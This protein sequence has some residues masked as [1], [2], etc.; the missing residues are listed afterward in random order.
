MG[1]HVQLTLENSNK[2]PNSKICRADFRE[3]AWLTKFLGKKLIIFK[4]W[5]IS[6][7]YSAKKLFQTPKKVKFLIFAN[8]L[9]I[10]QIDSK[11]SLK[12]GFSFVNP[13]ATVLTP[14]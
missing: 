9:Q 10:Y 13:L 5:P 2:E 7:V 3:I 1:Y 6:L 8:V 11:S 4:I 12:H 14:S